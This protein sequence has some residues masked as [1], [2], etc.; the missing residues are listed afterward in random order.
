MMGGWMRGEARHTAHPGPPFS[1]AQQRKREAWSKGG[2]FASGLA[3]S[4]WKPAV[5]PAAPLAGTALLWVPHT[6]TQ[7]SSEPQVM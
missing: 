3:A 5:P 7:P 2:T 1:R 4:R 6:Y